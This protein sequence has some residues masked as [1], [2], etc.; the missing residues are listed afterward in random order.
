M[1]AC[2][3]VKEEQLADNWQKLNCWRASP[4]GQGPVMARNQEAF[5]DIWSARLANIWTIG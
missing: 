3:F 1:G 2:F 4:R 5:A